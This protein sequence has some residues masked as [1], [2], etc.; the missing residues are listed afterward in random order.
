MPMSRN[1]VIGAMAL[2]MST[3]PT[4]AQNN[5]GNGSE[6]RG[7]FSITVPLGGNRQTSNSAPRFDLA[8]Q[9]YQTDIDELRQPISIHP[10]RSLRLQ[11]V[12][13]FTLEQN[14][15]LLVNGSQVAKFG[16]RPFNA[17][18]DNPNA[19]KGSGNTVL[20]IIGGVVAL[21]VVGGVVLA[22]DA[23]D[24]VSDLIGPED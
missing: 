17:D 10:R 21:G 20:Y 18:D 23:R 8:V 16:S 14:P 3:Q 6:M 1:L 15:K 11:S 4:A 9:S 19:D 12:M 24:A 13:S 2:A 5:S 7:T 22:T